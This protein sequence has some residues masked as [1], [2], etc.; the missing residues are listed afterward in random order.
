[1]RFFMNKKAIL[2]LSLLS[3]TALVQAV[4]TETAIEATVNTSALSSTLKNIGSKAKGYAGQI[5]GGVVDKGSQAWKS[6]AEKVGHV[7]GKIVKAEIRKC[8]AGQVQAHPYITA[9]GSAAAVTISGYLV[10][11]LVKR[12]RA[13]RRKAIQ[14]IINKYQTHQSVIR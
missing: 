11:R 8:L 12:F 7:R 6:V 2:V 1:M 3:S 9:A 5:K 13:R 10:Y 14:E 4:D